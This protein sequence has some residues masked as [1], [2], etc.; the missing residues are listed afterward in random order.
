MDMNKKEKEDYQ[1]LGLPSERDLNLELLK[2]Y[3]HEPVQQNSS[4]SQSYTSPSRISTNLSG[5]SRAQPARFAELANL[6][7]PTLKLL[8]RFDSAKV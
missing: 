6:I 8:L 5:N 2:I 3:F 4:M 7:Y 1:P